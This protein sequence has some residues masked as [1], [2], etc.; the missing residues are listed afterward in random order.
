MMDKFWRWIKSIFVD[1]WVLFHHDIA[2]WTDSND[3]L[4]NYV[5]YFLEYSKNKHRIRIRT[6][7][8]YPKAHKFYHTSI[9]PYYSKM[10]QFME[11]HNRENFSIIIKESNLNKI[12]ESINVEYKDMDIDQLRTLIDK[13]LREENYK[14]IKLI[15]EEIDR[16]ED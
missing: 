12:K 8:H 16:R 10:R 2:Y 3:K 5:H 7:G 1:D 4:T 6:T 15:Q 9:I 11:M 13:F 14:E